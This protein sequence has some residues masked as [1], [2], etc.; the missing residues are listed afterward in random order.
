MPVTLFSWML[1]G[2]CHFM[3]DPISRGRSDGIHAPTQFDRSFQKWCQSG[4]VQII[5]QPF[6]RHLNLVERVLH[7]PYKKWNVL[8]APADRNST[9]LNSSHV[10]IS[11]SVFY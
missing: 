11:Y 10:H 6:K 8:I 3:T 5:K 2:L 4:H 9:R 7:P 1:N